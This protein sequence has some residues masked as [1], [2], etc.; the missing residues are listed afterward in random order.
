MKWL[1]NVKYIIPLLL[2]AGVAQYALVAVNMIIFGEISLW[3]LESDVLEASGPLRYIKD[4]VVVLVAV[5]WV[6][7]IPTFN[8]SSELVSLL[9]TYFF[10]LT[11]ILIIGLIAFLLDYSPITFFPAGFRWLLL[12]HSAF[13]IFLISSALAV[14]TKSHVIIFRFI[15]VLLA[16]DTYAVLLQFA[17]ASSLYD[18]AFGAAR[19]PG[20]FSNAGIAAFFVIAITLISG[21]LD[22]ISL[23]AR[24]AVTALCVFLALSSGTRFATM[25][26]FI[27]LL[28]QLLEK[29]HYSNPRLGGLIKIML[30]PIFILLISFGY[31]ALLNQVDRGNAISDQFGSGGRVANFIESIDMLSD[32]D[33]GELLIGRGLGIGTN[34]AY[35]SILSA[36]INPE[37]YRFNILVDNSF[38]TCFFQ[39]GLVGSLIFWY[40]LGKFIFLVRPR[41]SKIAKI[42]FAG[43]ILVIFL[44]VVLGNPFEH[45]F[46]MMS[47]AIA[48]SCIYW[49][50][51]LSNNKVRNL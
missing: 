47:Y 32:G 16:L 15:L 27:F 40:G 43:T 2:F 6:I 24:M 5:A 36:G 22:G 25:A 50:D 51:R 31:E 7:F 42:R 19:L 4:L 37:T 35:S 41:K 49:T 21:Q 46:L 3:T 12:L 34:T 14:S 28:L 48:L 11:F 20:L 8:L 30:V 23:N 10:W 33:I 13:G 45:F 9:R 18:L 44:T 17:S 29:T 39:I 1:V 26:I 38:L